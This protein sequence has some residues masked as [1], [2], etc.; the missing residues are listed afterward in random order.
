MNID[1]ARLRRFVPVV[2]FVVTVVLGWVLLASP[3]VSDG[4]RAADRLALLKQREATLQGIVTAPQVTVAGDPV[5]SFDARVAADDPTGSI[6]ERLARLA[7]DTRARGLFIETVESAT[8]RGRGASPV[9]ST[10]QPDARFALFAQRVRYTTIRMSF[11]SDYAG[12][13]QFF[14][15]LRDLASIVEVR[16]L[17]VQPR[18]PS[19]SVRTDGTLRASLTLFAYSRTSVPQATDG[20][21][22]Q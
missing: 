4:A 2:V 3:I 8:S 15:R 21:V 7:S 9:A 13:G 19:V 20:V 18:V 17:N 14:W 11:E 12:L 6:V 5:A 16:T 1:F 10:Y 22:S